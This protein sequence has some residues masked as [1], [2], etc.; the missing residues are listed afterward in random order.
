MPQQTR[1]FLIN[2]D[3]LKDF[4]KILFTAFLLFL[5]FRQ[6]VLVFCFFY[7]CRQ[8]A[9]FKLLVKFLFLMLNKFNKPTA[10]SVLKINF[11]QTILSKDVVNFCWNGPQ[12]LF[13]RMSF[14]KTGDTPF[15]QGF[16][17]DV[18]YVLF[19]TMQNRFFTF[20]YFRF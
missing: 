2:V 1:Y 5:L 14:C 15:I 17:K 3:T 6:Y 10:E 13:E 4:F 7:I 20:L 19:K 8:V 9:S 16:F 12:A 18:Q 11:S